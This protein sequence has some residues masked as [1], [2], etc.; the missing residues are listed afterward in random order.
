MMATSVVLAILKHP[1][2]RALPLFGR[3]DDLSHE[4][5]KERTVRMA[6][7][8]GLHGGER[9]WQRWQQQRGWWPP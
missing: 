3:T 9:Q 8:L 1:A 2:L 5:E 6:N 4:Q 7:I